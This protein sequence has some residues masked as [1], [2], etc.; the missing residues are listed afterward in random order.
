VRGADAPV[1][2]AEDVSPVEA[3]S[4]E[5]QDG[6][7]AIGVVRK[8]PGQGPFPAVVM[9][10]GGL[11]PLPLDVLEVLAVRGWTMNRLLAAGYVIAI[12][13]RRSR[14]E[15]PP[16]LG[17]LRDSLAV[18]GEVKSMP[19]VDAESVV[20]VGSSG[21]SDLALE[22]AGEGG[23]VAVVAE[24]P[25]TVLFTAILTPDTPKRGATWTPAEVWPAEPKRHYTPD[26]Q[27]LTREK[28]ARID[29]PILVSQ[30]DQPLDG[31][32]QL[33]MINEILI[34]ELRALGR[35]VEEVVYPGQAHGFGFVVGAAPGPVA[36]ATAVAALEFFSDA[37]AFFERQL[38]TLLPRGGAPRGVL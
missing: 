24:E 8:P 11:D 13:T 4:V 32:H 6:S 30:G 22:V 15:P 25:A 23:I 1:L 33:R 19:E 16:G 12:P 7:T 38:P 9:L 36:E 5:T 17:A 14:P 34:P 31:A 2:I 20:L 10:H 3:L 26:L 28:I 18:V 35:Q 21:G 27:R 37:N 29:C